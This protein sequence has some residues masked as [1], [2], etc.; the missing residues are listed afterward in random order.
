[1]SFRDNATPSENSRRPLQ[2]LYFLLASARPLQWTKNGLV[3][4]APAAAGVLTEPG[5][6][7]KTAL[8]FAAF[9]LVSSGTY[10]LNDLADIHRDRRHPIKRTRPIA[11]GAVSPRSAATAAVVC[12]LAGVALGGLIRFELGML[13]AGYLALMS[14]YSF[15][16]K[17]MPVVDIACVAVGFFL[18]PIA[19]ALAID[20]S[21]SRWFLIVAAFTALYVVTAKRYA[22]L[23]EFGIDAASSRESLGHYSA[24]YLRSLLAMSSTVSILA[25]CLWAFEDGASETPSTSAAL[26]VIPFV[27]AVMR[28]GLL[29]ERGGGGE[30]E[31]V[32]LGDRQLQA[33]ILAW[34]IL[35]TLGVY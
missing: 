34:G 31:Q 24:D 17:R 21:I 23:Q 25:Y 16:L 11:S 10:F 28:Y 32:V 29:V 12:M 8:T 2:R 33:T 9:C 18:R 3:V 7:V 35:F 15:G 1:M 4:A 22:D 27:L 20:L 6:V 5:V 30:P 26:S 13:L 14:A 19:G